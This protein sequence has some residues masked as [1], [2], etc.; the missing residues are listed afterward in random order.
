M[1]CFGFVRS[2]VAFQTSSES[3]NPFNRFMSPSGN[4]NLYS[5]GATYS[6]PITD[7]VTLN[8]SSNVYLNVRARNDIAPAGW[9]GLG[10]NL[11]YGGISC[12]HKGTRTHDDDEFVWRSPAGFGSKIA[13]KGDGFLIED[14]PYSRIEPKDVNGDGV[15]DGWIVTG[16]DGTQMKYGNLNLSGDRKAT[17]WTFAWGDYVGQGMSGSPV[18]YPYQWDLSSIEDVYGNEI[19]YEYQQEPE[20]LKV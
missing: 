17:R 8:Y 4:V 6:L 20:Y 13:R 14:D 18:Q 10:W 16:V 2:A 12:N 15:Y 19:K 1:L 11:N 5:G 9:C 7:Q 3:A